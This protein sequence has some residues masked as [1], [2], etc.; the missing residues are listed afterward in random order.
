MIRI[1]YSAAADTNLEDIWLYSKRLIDNPQ[2]GKSQSPS[3]RAIDLS[4]SIT[5]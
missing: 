5:M 3:E 2:I 4:R 1:M